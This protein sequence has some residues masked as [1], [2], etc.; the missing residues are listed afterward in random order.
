ME[1]PYINR[2]IKPNPAFNERKV[3]KARHD[4]GGE[5]CR[6]YVYW[7]HRVS[8]LGEQYPCQFCQMIG[9]KRDIFECFNESE[10]QNCGFYLLRRKMDEEEQI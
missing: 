6:D 9:R 3:F 5:P 8:C 4:A 10:W 1:C 2:D 7:I